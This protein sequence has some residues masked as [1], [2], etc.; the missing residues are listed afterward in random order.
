MSSLKRL[1]K[2]MSEKELGDREAKLHG[3]SSVCFILQRSIL[4]LKLDTLREIR[5]QILLC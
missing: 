4:D 5:M 3:S 1:D 2:G